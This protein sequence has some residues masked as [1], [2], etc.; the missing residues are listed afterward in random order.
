MSPGRSD[1]PSTYQRVVD[2]GV[3]QVCTRGDWE[4]ELMDPEDVDAIAAAHDAGIQHLANEHHISR[5]G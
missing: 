5:T 2:G 3:R 4:T 1:V